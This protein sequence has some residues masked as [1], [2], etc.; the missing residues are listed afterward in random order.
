MAEMSGLPEGVFLELATV[1]GLPGV[2]DPT[3]R[4][5]L[6]IDEIA[7]CLGRRD[8]VSHLA[9]RLLAK[10][11]VLRSL[12]WSAGAKDNLPWQHVTIRR[13]SQQ[14]PQVVLSGPLERWRR[15]HGL[16]VPAVTLTHA[17]GHIAALAW[18]V[19]NG[20]DRPGPDRPASEA[21]QR[22]V[23]TPRQDAQW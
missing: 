8:T 13:S 16:A 9:A 10:R 15:L 20:P 1:A 7:F 17:A 22:P 21:A 14:A 5:H 11:A 19:S 23:P 12:G 6:T 4:R 18:L 3:W 2:D